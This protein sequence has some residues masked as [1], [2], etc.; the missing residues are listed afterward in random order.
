MYSSSI[1][2][3]AVCLFLKRKTPGFRS[4]YLYWF[5]L[6][7]ECSYRLRFIIVIFTF[8]FAGNLANEIANDLWGPVI[9]TCVDGWHSPSIGRQGACSHHGGVKPNPRSG[10]I[11]LISLVSALATYLFLR[12][13]APRSSSSENNS[14]SS[15]KYR[16]AYVINQK[17][18]K[19]TISEAE[20]KRRRYFAS[21]KRSKKK[22]R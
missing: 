16:H 7:K 13:F 1:V 14:D 3:I 22:S 12:Y 8:F 4:R 20:R 21:K 18:I 17:A 2:F 5:S 9:I 19:P 10:W 6:I 11:F 15:G